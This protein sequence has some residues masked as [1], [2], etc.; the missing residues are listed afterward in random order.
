MTK[1]YR[2]HYLLTSLAVVKRTCFDQ[3]TGIWV[4]VQD[5]N[6]AIIFKRMANY[7]DHKCK[8]YVDMDKN[9]NW[10][11]IQNEKKRKFKPETINVNS[12][13]QL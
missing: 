4:R 11:Q 3:L 5:E 10:Q 13:Q 6:A 2:A 9:L 8:R 1:S 7:Q 12:M